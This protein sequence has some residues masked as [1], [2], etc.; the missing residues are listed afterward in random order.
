MACAPFCVVARCLRAAVAAGPSTGSA[1]R[2]QSPDV[3]HDARTCLQPAE[4]LTL[5][6]RV[7]RGLSSCCFSRRGGMPRSRK[8]R[9]KSRVYCLRRVPG[10]ERER[11]RPGCVVWGG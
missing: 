3:P 9:G 8:K 7:P 10:E 6:L 5:F 2:A 11:V 1:I 4:R